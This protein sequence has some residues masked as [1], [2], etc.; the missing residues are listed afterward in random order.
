VKGFLFGTAVRIA[1]DFRRARAKERT[2]EGEIDLAEDPRPQPDELA[3]HKRMRQLLDRVLDELELDTRAVFVLFEL[4]GMTLPEIAE[5]LAVPQGTISS[6]LRRGR[7]QF[8]AAST[9]LQSQLEPER[10]GA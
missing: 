3:H 6:R 2:I 9:K 4:E 10:G 7:E 5:M 1:S 8:R